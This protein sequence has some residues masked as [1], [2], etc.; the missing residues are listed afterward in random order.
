MRKYSV[1]LFEKMWNG[2]EKGKCGNHSMAKVGESFY[3]MYHGNTIFVINRE[4]NIV[5]VDNCGYY[6]SSTTQAINSHLEAFCEYF[7]KI[8]GYIFVDVT[9]NK[10]FGKKIS[11]IFGDYAICLNPTEF[12][13]K[14][15]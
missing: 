7:G 11:Q 3:F 4:D 14:C 1:D 15:K 5:I 6:N 8:N 9:Q 10:K 2:V 12:H 13:E